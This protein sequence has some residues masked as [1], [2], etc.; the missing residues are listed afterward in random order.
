M[1]CK[2]QESVIRPATRKLILTTST[3]YNVWTS[4]LKLPI[5]IDIEAIVG[6]RIRLTVKA[7]TEMNSHPQPS[8]LSVSTIM[9]VPKFCSLD[10]PANCPAEWIPTAGF[11]NRRALIE[12]VNEGIK[13]MNL[14]AQVNY[15]KLHMEGIRIDKVS[16]K[17][18]HK[19][20]PV[21]PIWREAEVRR[22]L[23]L[24]PPYKAKIAEKAAKLLVGGLTN[25]GDWTST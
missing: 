11:N 6:G 4:N 15:L 1:M 10:L 5:H 17:T 25:I 3:L 24:T 9:L 19:H 7:H 23:H 8:T 2:T 12:E 21:K 16:K 18:L 13:T 22:R 14:T 20:Y